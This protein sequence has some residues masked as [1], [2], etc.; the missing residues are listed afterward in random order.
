MLGSFVLL[1]IGI[2]FL[3]FILKINRTTNF[4]PG[5]KPIQ[6]FGNLLHLSL[7][8]HLKDL[9]KLAERYGK[10]F[11]LYIG[12]RPAVILNGL[13]AMK[14]ALVTKALD[15][16]RRPQNLMLNHYTRKKK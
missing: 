14:E 13:E 5:P 8:N 9:E 11:S 10:V 3:F 12:G 16:A 15:F 7:R 6:I 2:C 1:W 4:P